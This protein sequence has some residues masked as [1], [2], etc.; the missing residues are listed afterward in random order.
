MN[1]LNTEPALL[2]AGKLFMKVL[3]DIIF[4]YSEESAEE[5]LIHY[6]ILY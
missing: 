1:H 2:L 4:P 6:V 3:R 5:F